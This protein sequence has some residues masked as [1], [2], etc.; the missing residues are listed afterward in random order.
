MSRER[1]LNPGTS[2]P[3][4]GW[5]GEVDGVIVPATEIANAIGGEQAV[6]AEVLSPYGQA[7]RAGDDLNELLTR[8]PEAGAARL[9]L[10]VQGV[11]LQMEDALASGADGIFYRIV[12]ADPTHCSPM[13]YGGLYLERDRELLANVSHAPVNVIYVDAGEEAYLDFLSD[14]PA[15]IFAWS[16]N[17]TSIPLSAVREMRPGLLA[18]EGEDADVALVFEPTRTPDLV[19]ATVG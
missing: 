16:E 11:K 13:Q 7:L 8:D 14:L 5:K 19:E 9:D 17:R 15:S 18:T 2:K 12:G 3:S 6:L 4:I 1:L 10:W